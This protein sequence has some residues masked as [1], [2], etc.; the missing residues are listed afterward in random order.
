MH[1]EVSK[2]NGNSEGDA[3]MVGKITK[4]HTFHGEEGERLT[5]RPEI[6]ESP[7]GETAEVSLECGDHYFRT[8]LNRKRQ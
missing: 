1:C 2:G 5:I 6:S 3:M 7:D 4:S 8:L